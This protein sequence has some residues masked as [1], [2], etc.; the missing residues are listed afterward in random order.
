[1]HAGV[2]WPP[3]EYNW[4][5]QHG[6]GWKCPDCGAEGRRSPPK[7]VP[8]RRGT[9]TYHSRGSANGRTTYTGSRGGTYYMTSGGKKRYI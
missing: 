2:T 9:G 7:R 4:G 3:L 8:P 6:R 1:M 5:N